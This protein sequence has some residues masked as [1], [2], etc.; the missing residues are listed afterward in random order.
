MSETPRNEEN[1][2]LRDP[3]APSE[4]G[5]SEVHP[6]GESSGADE[7]TAIDTSHTQAV[8]PPPPA[9]PASPL[10]APGEPQGNPYASPQPGAVPPGPPP[11]NPYG[12]P[13][14]QAGPLAAG[15][16]PTGAQAGTPS[17]YGAP[18]YGQPGYGAPGYGPPAYGAPGYAPPGYAPPRSL[19]GN[20]IALLIV[21]GLTTLGCGFGIVA[22]IFAILAATHKDE[23]PASAKFTRW[24]WIALVAGFVLA[25]AVLIIALIAFGLSANSTNYNS[26]A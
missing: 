11:Q 17:P 5:R 6:P 2:E 26:G 16:Q 7:T 3:T 4:P 19:S 12:V 1:P 13:P 22:L 14:A 9:P 18:G 8:P 15:P 23:P 24:G 10:A 21:S 25:V 20:T